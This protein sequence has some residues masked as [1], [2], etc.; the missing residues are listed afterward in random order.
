MFFKC[1]TTQD[2]LHSR[3]AHY[4][5]TYINKPRKILKYSLRLQH[6]LSKHN[7]IISLFS[8]QH[9]QFIVFFKEMIS[10]SKVLCV[11]LLLLFCLKLLYFVCPLYKKRFWYHSSLNLQ[12]SMWLHRSCLSHFR[13]LKEKSQYISNSQL[14]LAFSWFSHLFSL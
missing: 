8:E 11:K 4:Q 12:F 2:L 3:E 6:N 14:Y 7:H 10:I 13:Q 5:W 1:W 9:K